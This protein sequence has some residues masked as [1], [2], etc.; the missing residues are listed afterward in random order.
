MIPP[1]DT[2]VYT[3]YSCF[4]ANGTL[5]NCYSVYIEGIADY[6]MFIEGM[7]MVQC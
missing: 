2:S 3:N 7:S 1:Y 5:I 6:V 4:G